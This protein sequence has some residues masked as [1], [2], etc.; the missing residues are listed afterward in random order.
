MLDNRVRVIAVAD[1]IAAFLEDRPYRRRV[2]NQDLIN[3]EVRA[4]VELYFEGDKK[5]AIIDTV[6]GALT[7][8]RWTSLGK[9]QP[10]VSR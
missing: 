5:E 4:V 2:A 3:Q 6:N 7:M 1:K 10:G 9:E 8:E